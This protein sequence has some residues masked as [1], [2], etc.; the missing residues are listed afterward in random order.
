MCRKRC[1]FL[2]IDKRLLMFIGALRVKCV[3]HEKGCKVILRGFSEI[4]Q[5]E[6]GEC[7][8]PIEDNNS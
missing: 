6:N 8:F 5:H 1:D 2:P 3:N 4:Q 7:R